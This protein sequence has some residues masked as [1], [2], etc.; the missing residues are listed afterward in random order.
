MKGVSQN[1]PHYTINNGLDYRL[2][3]VTNNQSQLLFTK[4]VFTYTIDESST[5]IVS[6]NK[7]LVKY[8]SRSTQFQ[9]SFLNNLP[10]LS[11]GDS[12][13]LRLDSINPNW[14]SRKT[15]IA[16]KATTHIGSV[17]DGLVIDFYYSQYHL[18]SMVI[19]D[20]SVTTKVDFGEINQSGEYRM[21][22]LTVNHDSLRVEVWYGKNRPQLIG[23]SDL[24]NRA[25]LIFDKKRR[26]FNQIFYRT[27]WTKKSSKST[28]LIYEYNVFGKCRR[29]FR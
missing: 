10:V 15:V 18:D 23:H 4:K 22:S 26:F 16:A 13:V 9:L 29:R 19:N 14:L 1:H 11:I 8:K 20:S 12:L 2:Q 27:L 3:S 28:R 5:V 24:N 25:G 6:L 21:G 7:V 17:F